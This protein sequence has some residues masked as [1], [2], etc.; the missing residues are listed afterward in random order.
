MGNVFV[1][2][3]WVATVV[4]VDVAITKLPFEMANVLALPALVGAQPM[5][6]LL[7]NVALLL[8][9]SLVPQPVV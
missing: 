8:K 9:S 2:V 1:A 3:G 7:E 5:V 6:E 4:D